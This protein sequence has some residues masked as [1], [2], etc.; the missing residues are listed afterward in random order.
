MRELNF[1]EHNN[2]KIIHVSQENLLDK[3]IIF[4][5]YAKYENE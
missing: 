2:Y 4:G 3:R 5:Y 1:K